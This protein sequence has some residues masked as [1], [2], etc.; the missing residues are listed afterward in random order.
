MGMALGLMAELGWD[1]SSVLTGG[2]FSSLGRKIYR[3]AK[4][5]MMPPAMELIEVSR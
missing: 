1:S 5:S 4:V 3:A 2:L